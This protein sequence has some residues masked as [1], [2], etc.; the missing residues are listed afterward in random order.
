[1]AAAGGGDNKRDESDQRDEAAAFDNQFI[2]LIDTSPKLALHIQRY[3]DRIIFSINTFAYR[4]SNS[5]IFIE[6]ISRF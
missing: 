4:G 6:Y 3:I 5:S 2:L 1:M